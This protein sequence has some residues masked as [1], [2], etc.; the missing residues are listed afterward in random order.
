M[1]IILQKD[2]AKLGQRQTVVDVSDGYAFNMLIPQGLALLATPAN[3]KKINHWQ[4]QTSAYFVAD[5]TAYQEALKDLTATVIE[6]KAEANPQGKL[7]KGIK[8]SDVHQSLV[9]KGITAIPVEAII[10]D[11]PIKACG[12]YSITTSFHGHQDI[13]KINI[14]SK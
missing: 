6:I 4:A 1:K 8:A 9:A 7:F 10:I 3:L 2:V 12:E 5:E 13:I 11:K 14:I